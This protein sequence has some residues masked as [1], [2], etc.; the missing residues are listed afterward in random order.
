MD[1]SKIVRHIAFVASYPRYRDLPPD[2]APEVA[3]L[4]RSNVGKSSL[5]N[6][7]ATR[8]RLAKTS[9][10]PG[11]TVT[12]NYFETDAGYYLVDVPGLGYAKT[13]RTQR[14]RWAADLT[15]YLE[16]RESLAL[17][18]ILMD[19]RH[20]PTATDREAMSFVKA[21]GRPA[22]VVLTKIDK[23]SGNARTKTRKRVAD[24]MK[25]QMIEW[26][27]VE[28]SATA[29]RGREELLNWIEQI[30]GPTRS[31]QK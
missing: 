16:S 30:L 18:L 31:S 19:A 29:R 13:S 24:E 26:P 14:N 21:A 10:T 4:G 8:K 27:V 15:T 1:A 25:S 2:S 17:V 6:L 11:K 9:G 7:L 28:T 3:L 22:V 5:V 12:F 20:A 23:L